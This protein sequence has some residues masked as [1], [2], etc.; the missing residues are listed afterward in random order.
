VGVGIGV[1]NTRV[2][3]LDERLIHE[4]GAPEAK[5]EFTNNHTT[6]HHHMHP[7]PTEELVS[8][9]TYE[10]IQGMLKIKKATVMIDRK[11]GKNQIVSD[12]TVQVVN[13]T[14]GVPK[15]IKIPFGEIHTTSESRYNW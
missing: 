7:P 12:L 3:L 4:D 5:V 13:S 9:L 15:F 14:V 6:K 8:V 10:V 1:K 2:A 11:T